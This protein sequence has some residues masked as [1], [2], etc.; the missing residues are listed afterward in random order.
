MSKAGNKKKSEQLGM[1]HGT[2]NARLRKM[3]LFSLIQE[4]NK[5]ICFQCGKKIENIDNLSIEHKIP[6]LDNDI[7][8][9]WDLDNIAFSHL[10]CNSS[11][12]RR[13]N[14]IEWPEGKAWCRKCKEFKDL[15]I[16]FPECK[17]KDRSI[18]CT[19]CATIKSNNIRKR[20]KLQGIKRKA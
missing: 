10:K 19:K 17:N 9:F 5:D 18:L 7:N 1:P 3:I 16:D 11:A 6:W 8:L 4:I 20:N 12:G 15:A 2:A 13:P 14:K